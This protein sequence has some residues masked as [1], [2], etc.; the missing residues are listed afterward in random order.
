MIIPSCFIKFKLNKI[1]FWIATGRR[2]TVVSIDTDPADLLK[3]IR[4]IKKSTFNEIKETKK[5]SGIDLPPL[6]LQLKTEVLS[7]IKKEDKK[8]PM[9]IKKIRR[10]KIIT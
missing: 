6:P 3:K 7:K 4:Q 9:I 5:N 10:I 1:C 2:R 8:S